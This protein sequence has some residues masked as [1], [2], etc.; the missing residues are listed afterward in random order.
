MH[1]FASQVFYVYKSIA[2]SSGI[3]QHSTSLVL[4]A[5]AGQCFKTSTKARLHPALSANCYRKPVAQT[6]EEP[7]LNTLA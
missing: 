6:L 3:V 4:L 2:S 5:L 1:I 7:T